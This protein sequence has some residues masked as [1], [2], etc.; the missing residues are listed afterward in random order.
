[1]DNNNTW[2]VGA[3]GLF[4]GRDSVIWERIGSNQALLT[5]IIREPDRLVVGAGIGS[6]LYEW[7]GG[8]RWI[9]LHDETVTEVLALA[10]IAGDPGI[11]V[12]SPYGIAI[13]QRDET[14]AARWTHC[15]DGLRV[16]E[17][18][19]NAI[20]VD[21]HDTVRWLVGTEAGVLIATESG[22]QWER[23]SLTGM[24]VRALRHAMGT[25]WAGTDDHGIWR[26]TDGLRWNR[27]G[28]GMEDATVYAL[29]ESDGRIIA[30]TRHGA[31]VGDGQGAWTRLGPRMLT[32]AVAAHPTESSL[33][34]SGAN[35]GGLWCTN[36]NGATWCQIGGF[37]HVMAILA[38]E[39]EQA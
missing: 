4:R 37:T 36:D 21:P 9:Q 19:T 11:V 31:A 20:L 2:L 16:N 18:F 3:G 17:R 5:S 34:L 35:P 25:F 27:A 10:R 24:P 1:M 32:T 29:T 39:G 14:G 23:T 38:P 12:G 22:A 13:G 26:S 6:G 15:S 30:G 33:W 28:R 8:D 7:R